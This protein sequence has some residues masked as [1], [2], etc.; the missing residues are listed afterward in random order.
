MQQRR[1]LAQN[2][3]KGQGHLHKLQG[4]GSLA[5]ILFTPRG[6][7]I[8]CSC[9]KSPQSDP[10]PIQSDRYMPKGHPKVTQSYQSFAMHSFMILPKAIFHHLCTLFGPRVPLRVGRRTLF[11][12]LFPPKSPPGGRYEAPSYPHIPLFNHLNA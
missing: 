9:P 7:N 4:A 1:P 11:R 6:G 10:K 5:Q 3:C 8:F 12:S 2:L